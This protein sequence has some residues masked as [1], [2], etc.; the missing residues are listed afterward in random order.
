[1]DIRQL[2]NHDDEARSQ[3][4]KRQKTSHL[5]HEPCLS[6]DHYTVAWICALHI[7]LAAARAMLDEIHQD[8]SRYAKDDNTY[9]LGSIK[10]HNVV[11]S[12]SPQYGT[13]H[14]ANVLTNMTRTF[15]S[16]Q[17]GLMVGIGVGAPGKLDIRLGDIVVGTR[18]M[19]YDLEKVMA[20]GEVHRI[21]TPKFPNASL[22]SAVMAVRAMHELQ[23]SRVPAILQERMRGHEEYGRPSTPDRLFLASNEHEASAF[24]CRD[25]NQSQLEERKTRKHQTPTIFHG[26]I[27]SGNRVIKNAAVRDKLAQ[28]LDVIC[29]EMEAAGLMDILS[30]LPIRGICDYSDSH[31]SKE[32]QR[33]AAATAAAYAREF[34]RSPVFRV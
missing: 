15:P 2:L 20:K 5:S 14:A 31:K 6:Y 33:Y 7:E 34:A 25:C 32:W 1:M 18:V 13:N 23:P 12:C 17:F 8:L 30:C 29:F 3:I 11:I 9:T 4:S 16:I 26:G 24:N 22:Q 28:E 27:A 19:Q 10:Q 21:A